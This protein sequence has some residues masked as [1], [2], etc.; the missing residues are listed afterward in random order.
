M[1]DIAGLLGADA[2]GLLTTSARAS[3][4]KRCTCPGRISSTA[5]SRRP[6]AR[7]RCCAACSSCSTTAGSAGTGYLSI[8]P[9][10]QGI[11]HSAGASFAPEPGCTSTPRTSSS[12]PSKAAATPW[13]RRSAC[14]APCSRK[15]AHKIP[16]LLKFNHNEFLTYPEQVRPDLVRQRQAGARHGRGRGRRDRSTSARPN[17]RRQIVEVS[18][19]FQMAHELGMAT[20]LWCYLRNPAFK[21]GQGL[22]R[23]RR[24]HRPGQP[25]G[26]D[27]RG[28]HHQAEAA[29]EQRRLQRAQH[30]GQSVRQDRQARVHASSPPTIRSISPAT[31]SP[32]ATWAARA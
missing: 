24:P 25:S 3:R 11:E 14:S 4:R 10:D 16:F 6:T 27:H 22:S 32:T 15:Y 8:L 29:R 9:V 23:V 12:S 7:R 13:P 30:Q 5:S 21:T 18:Q 31:R 20:V 19:A 1:T 2:D 26:R 28:R 17:R